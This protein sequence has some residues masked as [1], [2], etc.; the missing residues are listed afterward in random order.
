M[1]NQK[2]HIHY[3]CDKLWESLQPTH[4]NNIKFCDTC[5]KK[6]GKLS[7]ENTLDT[8]CGNFN[9]SQ[10]DSFRRK[11]HL[12]V[13]TVP[14]ITVLGLS[15]STATVNAQIAEKSA[16]RIENKQASESIIIRGKIF[17]KAT[18]FP[19]EQGVLEVHSKDSLIVTALV[20][21]GQFKLEIDTNQYALETL[22]VVFY[23]LHQNTSLEG[24]ITSSDPKKFLIELDV[25]MNSYNQH[26][27][28][29][30]DTGSINPQAEISCVLKS[31]APKKRKRRRRLRK[32]ASAIKVVR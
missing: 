21:N 11:F 22:S 4:S 19:I 7:N 28:I 25:E 23:D 14:L 10:V 26:L 15:L 17:E 20:Q 12:G 13:A 32:N 1:K 3:T 16:K 31:V 24:I 6:V 5:H 2:V 18:S 30:G 29:T 9:I 8:S 27:T